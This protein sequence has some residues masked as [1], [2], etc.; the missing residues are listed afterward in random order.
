M[1]RAPALTLSPYTTLFRSYWQGLLERD[2]AV[3]FGPVY[4]PRGSWG[5]GLLDVEDEQEARAV[6]DADPAVESGTCTY[7]DRKSTRLNSSHHVI[8]YAVFCLKTKTQ[9]V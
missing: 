2:V 8:S 5:L 6:A 7:E 1:P 3:A 4:D 9:T